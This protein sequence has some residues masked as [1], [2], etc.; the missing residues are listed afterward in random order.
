MDIVRDISGNVP[1][2]FVKFGDGEYNA[3]IRLH[4]GNCDGTPYTPLLGEKIIEAFKYLSQF[5]NVYIG[6]WADFNSVAE[7]W[8]NLVP[9]PFSW[10]DY[11]ILICRSKVDFLNRGLQYF[12]AIRDAEQQK[13]YVCNE[14]MI[15]YSTQL[16]HI[17]T[18]IPVD[19]RNWFETS[20]EQVVT[21]TKKAV[22]DPKNVI[23]L[24]SAG[25]GAKPLIAEFWKEYPN[26]IIIDIGSALDV[27]C[28]SRKSRDY[29]GIFSY[30]DI[31]EIRSAI[32]V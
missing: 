5:K 25:M 2:V 10:A 6:K 1:F 27:V 19:P 3:A 9:Y 32:D 30:Q 16:L 20:Y 14:S 4:G 12:K 7:Y 15:Q 8:T 24:T 31:Q 22:R 23:L 18:H 11:N 13:I 29:H 26:A 21:A 17:D 28:G